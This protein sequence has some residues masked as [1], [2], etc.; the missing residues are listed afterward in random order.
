[1]EYGAIFTQTVFKEVFDEKGLH[2]VGL[3]F[4]F[5][6]LKICLFI[7]RLTALELCVRFR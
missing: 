2:T 4:F 6:H 7:I 1:M 3:D 5:P